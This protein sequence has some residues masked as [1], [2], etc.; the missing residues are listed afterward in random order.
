M[1]THV[2]LPGLRRD[3]ISQLREGHDLSRSAARL[4]A[5]VVAPAYSL[6]DA[7]SIGYE[8]LFTTTCRGD[9]LTNF[10]PPSSG[11][12]NPQPYGGTP[13]YG[14]PPGSNPG[15]LPAYL[16]QPPSGSDQ[17]PRTKASRP[18][19]KKKR[20]WLLGAVAMLIIGAAASG[21]DSSKDASTPASETSTSS[22]SS[23]S[24]ESETAP[25]TEASGA[26][27]SSTSTEESTP[28]DETTSS[29]ASAEAPS[30]TD[31]APAENSNL[32][33]SQQNAVTSAQSYLSFSAFSRQGLIDQ[34]SSQ[35]AD[36]Y[37][38][39]DATVAVDSLN[40][41]W[42]AQAAKAAKSYLDMTGFSCQ[43]LIDQLASPY[44]DKYTRAQA[45]YGAKQSG[46]C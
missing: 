31:E 20:F 8:H 7:S 28:S 32:T 23:S 6:V 1:E 18:W 13:P 15:S 39:K 43:G 17:D 42:N 5:A 19:F 11:D 3:A 36:K 12:Q 45:T 4:F 26:V 16:N 10:G 30:T 14:T 27:E 38:V 37:P 22:T 44:A 35:Y 29:E 34:L 40:V 33:P 9:K 24:S 25:S 2:E 41:D 46:I 21:A